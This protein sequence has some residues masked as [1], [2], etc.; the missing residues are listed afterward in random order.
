ME[1]PQ[2]FWSSESFR[3]GGGVAIAGMAKVSTAILLFCWVK[4][5]FSKCWHSMWPPPGSLLQGL[6]MR[7]FCEV[8]GLFS[9]I[10]AWN[11]WTD[12]W[13]AGYKWTE[14][15]SRFTALVMFMN[16]PHAVNET[17]PFTYQSEHYN[18]DERP[19][20]GRSWQWPCLSNWLQMWVGFSV[21]SVRI[22]SW[23]FVCGLFLSVFFVHVALAGV[24]RKRVG[25][26]KKWK[27]LFD[28]SLSLPLG[29]FPIWQA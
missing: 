7:Y 2:G 23:P 29:Q 3:N 11:A 20:L 4:T 27:H 6:R 19:L 22:C 25:A 9:G 28:D 21:A 12:G 15:A 16:F 5:W 17:K 14:G 24:L 26:T 18:I 1:K 10:D 13:L 8:Q